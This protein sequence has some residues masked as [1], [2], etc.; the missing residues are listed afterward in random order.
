MSRNRGYAP[1]PTAAPR[2]QVKEALDPE[3]VFDAAHLD[4][5]AAGIGWRFKAADRWARRVV[6]S[7]LTR[8]M[9]FQEA[10]RFSPNY[11]QNHAV[12]AMYR[13]RIDEYIYAVMAP[14]YNPDW[15]APVYESKVTR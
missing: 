9:D 4:M 15:P 7:A 14:F 8:D 11:A 2:F 1:Q 6:H 10:N 5:I 13:R 12:Q 3:N